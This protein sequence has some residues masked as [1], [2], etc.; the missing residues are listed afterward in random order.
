MIEGTWILR[1]EQAIDIPDQ[2]AGGQGKDDADPGSQGGIQV[3]EDP[4]EDESG[5][6]HDRRE[7]QIDLSR[8]D[9]EGEA[10]TENKRGGTVCRKDM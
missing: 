6:R 7:A 3:L 5:E 10:Q 4:G 8:G 2:S 9:D 1:D